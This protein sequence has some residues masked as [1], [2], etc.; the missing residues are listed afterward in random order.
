MKYHLEN[1]VVNDGHYAAKIEAQ[2]R[3]ILSCYSDSNVRDCIPQPIAKAKENTPLEKSEPTRA[4]DQVGAGTPK[5]YTGFDKILA[6]ID[7]TVKRVLATGRK[8]GIK[9]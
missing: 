7:I 3:K 9:K 1:P 5:R 2:K 8:L 4:I 6:D